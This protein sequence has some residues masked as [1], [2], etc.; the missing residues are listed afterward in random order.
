MRERVRLEVEV[1]KEDRSITE[2]RAVSSEQVTEAQRII[3]G[4]EE[5][6]MAAQNK[7]IDKAIGFLYPYSPREGQRDALYHLIYRQKNLILIAKTSF[8]ESMILQAVFILLH[9]SI[10]L[11]I[12]PLDQISV[13]QAEYI[14]QIGGNPCFLNA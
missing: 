9:K 5:K 13:E 10:T 1:A 14:A 7:A 6:D 2:T 12:L 3:A 11:V 8:R 4:A